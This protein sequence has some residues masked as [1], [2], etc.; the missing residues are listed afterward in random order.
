MRERVKIDSALVTEER[1]FCADERVE[2]A[3]DELHG[4]RLP[5]PLGWLLLRGAAAPVLW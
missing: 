4:G 3:G 1:I 2:R 5:V